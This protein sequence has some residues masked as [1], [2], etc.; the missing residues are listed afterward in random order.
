MTRFS[1]RSKSPNYFSSARYGFSR[2]SVSPNPSSDKDDQDDQD[3]QDDKDGKD[4][5]NNKNDKEVYPPTVPL[6]PK[7]LKY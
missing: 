1:A 7:A 3:D 5:K 4:D 2:A 6:V